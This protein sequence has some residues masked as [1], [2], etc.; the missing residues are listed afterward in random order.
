MTVESPLPLHTLCT[1]HSMCTRYGTFSQPCQ[2]E[3]PGR[4]GHPRCAGLRA[5]TGVCLQEL[6]HKNC[7]FDVHCRIL[8]NFFHARHSNPMSSA[9][10]TV[11][12]LWRCLCPSID[13]VALS[14]AI[15]RPYRPRPASRLSAKTTCA[16][17]RVAPRR[18]LHTTPPKLQDDSAQKKEEPI[19]GLTRSETKEAKDVAPKSTDFGDRTPA[20]KFDQEAAKAW[21][22]YFDVMLVEDTEE[23]QDNNSSMSNQ[24]VED[25]SPEV[26]DAEAQQQEDTVGVISDAEKEGRHDLSPS[27]RNIGEQSLP[28][29]SNVDAEKDP[30]DDL[31]GPEEKQYGLFK[32]NDFGEGSSPVLTRGGDD[33]DVFNA[34]S[35]AEDEQQ[36]KLPKFD[37]LEEDPSTMVAVAGAEQVSLDGFPAPEERQQA[38]ITG[39][40]DF[41][42]GSSSMVDNPGSTASRPANRETME[43]TQVVDGVH[44]VPSALTRGE[45]RST[46]TVYNEMA[47]RILQMKPPFKDIPPGAEREDIL[48]ALSLARMRGPRKYRR[49]IATLLKHLLSIDPKPTA[50]YYDLLFRAH[51]SPE[52]SADTIASLLKEMRQERI[53][54]SS[55]AYH[56]VLR[57]C[58]PFL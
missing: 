25:L 31:F 32:P 58:Y 47:D 40:S 55:V 11:D 22:G 28:A 39:L 17:P 19:V 56:S 43:A 1:V 23:R 18:H 51:S 42:I 54:W 12:G 7:S 10:I 4:Q 6:S 24:P 52:G 41:G 2:L 36:R 46:R 48:K 30:F 49:I 21:R 9:R 45:S 29:F 20:V 26:V 38:G 53:H 13:A 35:D 27:S 5:S 3:A 33:K 57:V 44:E 14:T 37:D 50:F 16:G 34:L 15:S 8:N